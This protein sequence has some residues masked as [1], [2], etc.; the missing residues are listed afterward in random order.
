MARGGRL[1]SMHLLDG[2]VADEED[3][4]PPRA[5]PH[6]HVGAGAEGAAQAA[7]G[8]PHHLRRDRE[9]ALSVTARPGVPPPA[10][11]GPQRRAASHQGIA[12]RLPTLLRLDAVP[13]MGSVSSPGG[14]FSLPVFCLK[15]V[16]P[17]KGL[18]CHAHLNE[19]QSLGHFS[20]LPKL[21]PKPHR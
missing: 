11:P 4:V 10:T 1:P 15:P 5:A 7:G 19:Q 9:Q 17:C 13:T 3:G 20:D 18:P 6:L 21:V 14:D 2:V 8:C 12:S 16:L